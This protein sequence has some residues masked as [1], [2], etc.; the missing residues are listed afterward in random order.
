MLS[1]SISNLRKTLSSEMSGAE[2]LG[3]WLNEGFWEPE[4]KK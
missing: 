1:D 3:F 2:T 4:R